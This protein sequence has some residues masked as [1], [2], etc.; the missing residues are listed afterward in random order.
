LQ[1]KTAELAR[2]LR[3]EKAKFQELTDDYRK[4]D[5]WFVEKL[6]NLLGET[7]QTKFD[8]SKFEQGYKRDCDDAKIVAKLVSED[9]PNPDE[10]KM[11]KI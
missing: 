3:V 10:D 4:R 8:V 9:G 6:Q 5:E 1:A 2:E 7:V 11:V